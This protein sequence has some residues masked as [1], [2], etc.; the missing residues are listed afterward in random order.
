MVLNSTDRQG[1]VKDSS[2]EV[3]DFMNYCVN[4][5]LVDINLTGTFFT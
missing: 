5:G 3:R 1:Q 4:L 2:Y